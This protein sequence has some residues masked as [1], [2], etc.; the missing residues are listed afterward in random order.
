MP[1][2]EDT[3]CIPLVNPIIVGG[4][5]LGYTG[6]VPR[7]LSVQH[8]QT[9]YECYR[10]FSSGWHYYGHL[11]WRNSLQEIGQGHKTHIRLEALAYHSGKAVVE[12][13]RLMLASLLARRR[14]PVATSDRAD[15]SHYF[16]A[17]VLL[18]TVAQCIWQSSRLPEKSFR[19]SSARRP[20]CSMTSFI[21]PSA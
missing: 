7:K 21:R 3:Q 20:P 11:T 2:D 6:E 14:R 18:G 12:A 9:Q 17:A 1:Q 13:W 4:A 10:L 5:C 19:K 16:P 8:F 15:T